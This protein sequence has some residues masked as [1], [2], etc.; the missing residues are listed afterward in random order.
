MRRYR[1]RDIWHW[2][3]ANGDLH[4]T[5]ED[6]ER[7]LVS[8][9]RSLVLSGANGGEQLDLSVLDDLGVTIAGRLG[10]FDRSVAQFGDD[11]ESSIAEAELEMGAQL[12][13]IDEHIAATS[14]EW[15]HEA[16]RL[17][18]IRIGPGLA[19][20]DLRTAGITT[21]IWATGY[22][23]DY[24][25]LDLPV[26]DGNAEIA[27]RHG[28]SPVAG[29]YTLGLSFQRYKASHFIGGVGADA[30]LLARRLFDLRAH[31]RAASRR[32]TAVPAWGG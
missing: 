18:G 2:L 20:L 29:L 27:Q 8:R 15:P 11:L 16:D 10:G 17:A 25:W 21:V 19:S 28:I 32:P 3:D 6:V 4:R 13:R 24:G 1:G 7:G 31:G 14:R 9:G 22:R 23:R 12:D 5:I 30:L 26:L